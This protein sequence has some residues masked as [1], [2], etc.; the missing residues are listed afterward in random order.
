M[1]GSNKADYER[2]ISPHLGRL[3]R[4]AYRL[5]GN[6]ADAED[7]VQ[8]TCVV[9]GEEFATL[10]RIEHPERWLARVLYNRFVDTARRRR[11]SPVSSVEI[12]AESPVFGSRRDCPEAIAERS[13]GERGFELAFARLGATQRAVLSLRAEGYGLAE[14]EAITGIARQVLRARLHRARLSLARYLVEQRDET[15]PP[16]RLGSQA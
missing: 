1:P 13:D 3:F 6:V 11:R 10:A 14:I 15:E 8:D 9:A 16:S 5:T 12:D 7:L 4:T 2:L